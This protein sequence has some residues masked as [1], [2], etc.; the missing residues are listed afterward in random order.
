MEA[1]RDVLREAIEFHPEE[2]LVIYNL[3][4]YLCVLG[5]VDEARS[6]LPKAFELESALKSGAMADPDLA[7]IFSDGTTPDGLMGD[8]LL[9]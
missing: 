7:A 2:G 4:C 1:A 5:Q 3:A 8:T 9:S 6:M